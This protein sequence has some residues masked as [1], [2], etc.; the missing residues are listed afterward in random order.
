MAITYPWNPF[1]ERVDCRINNEMIRPSTDTVRRE[2]VPRAAPFFSHNFVLTREGSNT[3][4]VHGVDYIF[5]HPFNLFIK[6]LKRN[7]FGSVI[8]LK[9]INANIRGAYDTIGD[10]FILDEV[11]YATLVANIANSP[12]QAYWENVVGQPPAFPPLPHPH[13]AS[14]T[15]DYMDM[16]FVL[17]DMLLAITETGSGESTL[18]L[19]QMF[20]DHINKHIMQAHGG[21]KADFGLDLVSNLRK[22]TVDDIKGG[23]DNVV[24]TMATL[25]EMFRL[26]ALGT[27]NFD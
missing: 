6:E 9:E 13:P 21:S 5:G 27:L 17:R 14:Q 1:Q 20:E 25:K 7:A 24:P 19:K 26:Q 3:P 16:M 23:S 8:L 10:P 18:T 22:A 4:L 2:F 15:Y 12:R 11:A